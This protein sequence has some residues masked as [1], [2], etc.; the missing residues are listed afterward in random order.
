MNFKELVT[1][2][3]IRLKLYGGS[4]MNL[5]KE[6]CKEAGQEHVYGIFGINDSCKSDGWHS[7]IEAILAEFQTDDSYS[8]DR[9]KSC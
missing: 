8:R 2:T 6:S 3:V 4:G 1:F 7:D 9:K 5:N